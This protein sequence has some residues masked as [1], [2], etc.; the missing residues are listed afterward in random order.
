MK[1]YK[2]PIIFVLV[3][4]IL[5]IIL[6][7]K[8][9][10]EGKTPINTT[11]S[12]NEKQVQETKATE[13]IGNQTVNPKK[14]DTDGD[15]V[16]DNKDNCPNEAGSPAN[17]GCKVVLDSDHDGVIDTKDNCPNEKGHKDN[18]GCK[19]KIIKTGFKKDKSSNENLIV[20][21]EELTENAEELEIKFLLEVSDNKYKTYGPF[22]VTN[23][24]SYVWSAQDGKVTGNLIK[25]VMKAKLKN[26]I[27]KISGPLEFADY[28]HCK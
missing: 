5:F 26:G 4:T 21:S 18:N 8:L 25:V 22:D 6:Y 16:V 17:K 19:I 28:F 9:D 15:G 2:I 14:I 12:K 23:Q 10:D 20:W 7:F 3:F 1:K 24:N 13:S 11:A 27:N